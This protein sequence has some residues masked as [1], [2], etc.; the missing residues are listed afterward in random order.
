MQ[1]LRTV[2]NTNHGYA[3]FHSLKP[4][5][6]FR[7][8]STERLKLAEASSSDVRYIYLTS[9]YITEGAVDTYIEVV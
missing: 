1:G 5:S 7:P 9:S 2:K 4:E 3:F 6:P 8:F